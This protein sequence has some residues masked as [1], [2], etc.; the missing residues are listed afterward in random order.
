MAIRQRIRRGALSQPDL[1]RILVRVP[2]FNWC[3]RERTVH[4][5]AL[6]TLLIFTG[7]GKRTGEKTDRQTAEERYNRSKWLKRVKVG[8][9]SKGDG[10][11]RGRS[12][13]IEQEL[14]HVILRFNYQSS[15]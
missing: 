2:R 13:H 15:H 9:G 12:I 11:I 5:V 4:I 10:D 14:H 1:C 7:L 6:D 3:G 8:G